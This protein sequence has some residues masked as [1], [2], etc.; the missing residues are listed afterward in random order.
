MSLSAVGAYNV[1]SI[2]INFDPEVKTNAITRDFRC[3]NLRYLSYGGIG[4]HAYE[5][6]YQP[7]VQQARGE[8]LGLFNLGST[9]VLFFEVSNA[10]K[11]APWCAC[12]CVCVCVLHAVCMSLYCIQAP[13]QVRVYACACVCAC[14]C[15][16]E[17]NLINWVFVF[18]CA[19]MSLLQ[20]SSFEWAV[21]I[22]DKVR[23]G[24]QLGR[25]GAPL[26]ADSASSSPAA[27]P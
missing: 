19:Y 15:I 16:R 2:V 26:E 18:K 4:T 17:S 14:A 20:C 12:T 22:G 24:Q 6:I 5:K 13:T 21:N 3:P 1:G 8:E 25:F 27:S 11:S 10:F 7:P 9:I 23:M